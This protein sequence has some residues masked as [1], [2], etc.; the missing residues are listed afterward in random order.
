MKRNYLLR[1]THQC[2]RGFQQQFLFQGCQKYLTLQ[3]SKSGLSCKKH[4]WLIF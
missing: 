2:E 3:F 1:K 4:I